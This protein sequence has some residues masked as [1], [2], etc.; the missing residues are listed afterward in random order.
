MSATLL[1]FSAALSLLLASVGLYGVLSYAVARRTREM[2][3]RM[4]LGAG[5]RTVRRVVVR[6]GLVL[7]SLG[8]ALGF[9]ASIAGASLLS[10][11]LYGVSPTDLAT[12][13]LVTG[14][15]VG[16]ALAASYL[17]AR[18]ATRVDPLIALRGE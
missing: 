7:V 3:I 14:L 10:S 18:R 6:Q 5:T 16:V 4:A 11:F 17:P 2:G 1:G 12:Y 13:A 8:V 9:L 15:L